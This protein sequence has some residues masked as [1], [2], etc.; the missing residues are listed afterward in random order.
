MLVTMPLESHFAAIVRG[1]VPLPPFITQRF[2]ASVASLIVAV[3]FMMG[4]VI[5]TDYQLY[6]AQHLP[7]QESLSCRVPA[8]L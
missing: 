8:V 1:L 5:A 3:P 4:A 7:S 6:P 2:R